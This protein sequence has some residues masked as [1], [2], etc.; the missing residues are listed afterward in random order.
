VKRS[1]MLVKGSYRDIA[2]CAVLAKDYR[3]RKQ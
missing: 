2:A 1:A 3:A